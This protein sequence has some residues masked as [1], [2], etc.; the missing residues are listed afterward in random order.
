MIGG[1]P[2]GLR[3]AEVAG[4]AGSV[5][6][7]LYDAKPSVGRKLLVAGKGGLN[8]TNS[9]PGEAFARHY[10]GPGQPDDFWTSVLGDFGPDELRA[11]ARDLGC[12]TFQ[13]S[14]GRVYPDSLK[15]A[16]L[17]RAW[18]KRLRSLNINF[19]A[20]HHWTGLLPVPEP[21]IIS[22]TF[23][24]NNR[25]VC[26]SFDAVVLALGGASWPST[27][28]TGKWTN[29]LEEQGIQI[30]P[31]APANS[32]WEVAWPHDW[33][34]AVEGLPLKNI[35]VSAG[36]ATVAGELLF[37][38]Y[39][40]EGGPIYT[41][42]PLLRAMNP[43]EITVDLKPTFTVERLVRKME[44]VRKDHLEAARVRWK[45]Q[46]AACSILRHQN[47][48]QQPFA[49]SEALATAVKHF[50][51]P[52]TRP[53]PVEEAISSAGGI[54]WREIETSTLMLR[55]LPGVFVAGEMID[56]EAPTG[57]YL[58]QGCF[59]TGTRAGKSAHAWAL[60]SN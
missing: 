12:E 15:A 34:A 47:R 28:S 56:W 44:S 35:K 29:A 26:S 50:V 25:T 20:N 9:E 7:T 18:V 5:A 46:P 43:P 39:G 31:F 16:P 54:S 55:N 32:G 22:L 8:L 59:A 11:W 45:L 40:V 36:D 52:L 30:T 38:R 58:L 51:I 21:R 2:A 13:A 48:E 3:A 4:S 17:L 42:G 1:G 23:Q 6:V 60:Q 27:G 10:S 37:T 49:S 33:L 57:G 41:L 53:R 24:S 14:S 19:A